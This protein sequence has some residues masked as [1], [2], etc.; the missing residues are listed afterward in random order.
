MSNST[1]ILRKQHNFGKGRSKAQLLAGLCATTML[2]T[3]GASAQD[4]T[5]DADTDIAFE[6]IVVTGLKREQSLQDVP[7]AV[8][9]FSSDTIEKMNI[10]RPEDFLQFTPNVQ[11][12]NSNHAGESLITI[13]GDAQTRNTEAPVAV[14]ID[15]VVMTGRDGFTGE[16]FDVEQIEV[17][18]GPQGY[19]YGRNAIA[20]AI[21]INTRAPSNEFEAAAT[22]GYGRGE[23][24]RLTTKLNIPIVEDKLFLRMA[25]ALNDRR[26]FFQNITTGVY[27]DRHNEKVGRFRLIWAPQDN[28]TFDARV[29]LAKVRGGATQFTPQTSWPVLQTTPETAILDINRVH[30]IPFV[31]NVLGFNEQDK[32]GYAL[33]IDYE[34]DAGTLT[35]VSTY[36]DILDVFGSD[37][38]PYFPFPS[39]TQF[40]VVSHEAF[41]QE[42]RFTSPSDKRLRYFVGAYYTDIDNTPNIHAAIGVD[43]VPGFVLPAF[44]PRG[45]DELNATTGLI[46]DNVFTEAWAVFGNVEYDL[47]EAVTVQVAGRYDKEDK[48][49]VDAS[50]LSPTFQEEREL[51]FDEFQPKVNLSWRATEN[52]TVYGGYARGFQAGGFNGAQTLARTGGAAPNE[53]DAS[54]ADNFEVGFKATLVDGAVFIS[55]AAFHNTK[56][57]AQQFLFVPAG[58][59]NA[60]ETIDEIEL[61]GFE[62]EVNANPTDSLNISAGIG[63]IDAEIT[64][65]DAKPQQ[66]GNT[67]PLVPDFTGSVSVTHTADISHI[68]PV[69]GLQLVSNV[70]YEYR[71]PTEFNSANFAP[72]LRDGLN[73]LNLRVALETDQWTLSF[74]ARNLTN[75]LYAEDVVTVDT[76]GLDPVTGI[77]PGFPGVTHVTFR[78]QPRTWGFEASFRF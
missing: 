18:K 11:M 7:A 67:A 52:L 42:I 15:G 33:K 8:T 43:D 72:T 65:F 78:S 20:G 57:N 22:V 39:G 76:D 49:S 2:G 68:F 53:F 17:L 60:V 64:E 26:G 21:V 4:S 71:G 55:G 48:R 34:T 6:E 38:F 27:E 25:G 1:I 46:S 54:T 14:V 28:L 70:G 51:S 31:R 47:S 50:P 5:D 56:S 32:E 63:Y 40:N 45:I 16:L 23:A 35:S 41:A 13:R 44:T 9:V 66:V 58:T 12:I 24:M 69:D 62:L 61:Q 73:L 36:D 29:N 10:T 74:W 59:L 30:E 3:I 75:E 37:D 77:D 19:L